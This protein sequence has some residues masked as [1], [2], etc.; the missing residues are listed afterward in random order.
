MGN[1]HFMGELDNPLET[2]LIEYIK[3]IWIFIVCLRLL[4]KIKKIVND[5]FIDQLLKY[6]KI[7]KCWKFYEY[8][9]I[10]YYI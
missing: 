1:Q 9:N 2:M 6:K 3:K 5:Y 7:L 10:G 4:Q 8:K